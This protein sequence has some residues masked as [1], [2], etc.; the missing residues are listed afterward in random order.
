MHDGIA[1][2][3]RTGGGGREDLGGE[4][5]RGRPGTGHGPGNESPHART[6]GWVGVVCELVPPSPFPAAGSPL[7]R[8]SLSCRPSSD[9]RGVCFPGPGASKSLCKSSCISSLGQSQPIMNAVSGMNIYI[10]I[11][12]YAGGPPASAPAPP[13]RGVSPPPPSALYLRF[14]GPERQG[15]GRGWGGGDSLAPLPT[16]PRC[17][18]TEVPPPPPPCRVAFWGECVTPLIFD[19]AI[20]RYALARLLLIYI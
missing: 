1:P 17:P 18:P 13:F 8:P 20:S 10:Y 4:G 9:Y 11:Y 5:T 3:P 15:A 2:L 14:D 7:P 6:G 19:D 16:G 12:I